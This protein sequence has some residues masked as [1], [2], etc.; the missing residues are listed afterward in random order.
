MRAHIKIVLCW[1]LVVVSAGS[2]A[3]TI[4]G[5]VT[6]SLGKPLSLV[7]VTLKG[8][9][10]V[11]I[12]FTS[13]KPTGVYTLEIPDDAPK[14][15]LTLEVSC[16]GFKKES[17][18]VNDPAA[19]INFK[20]SATSKKLNEVTIKNSRP[21]IRTAGDTTSYKVSDFSTPQD[22]V[23]GDVIKKLPGITVA[24]DGKISYNG[25]GVSTVYM[26]GDNLLD[27]KYNVATNSI[28]NK[29]VDQVQ[30]LENNQP[31]K[32]LQGKVVS[33]DVALNLTFKPD[34]KVKIVGQ[35]MLGGGLPGRY[36]EDLNAMAFKDRYKAINN[37]KG[38]NTGVDLANDVISH[39][40]G[41]YLG[42]LDNDKPTTVLSLGTAGDP[43]LPRSR[44]LFNQSGMINLNNLVN[45]TKE[46]QVKANMY[47][48]HDTQTQNYSKYSKLTLNGS[49]IVYTEQQ[50]NRRQPDILHGQFTLN[51]NKAKYYLNNT[52]LVDYNHNTNYSD[53][54]TNGVYAGQTFKD[55]AFDLSNEFRLINTTKG[56][57]IYEL[58]SYI[59][60]IGEPE[61][62]AITPGINQAD[63][64]GGNPYAQLVQGINIPTWFTN[65][66]VS[67]KIP[68]DAVTQS[69]K[70]GASL[71]SQ[72]VQSDL[73]VVQ[74]NGAINRISNDFNSLNWT[75]SKLYGEAAFD[76]PGKVLKLNITL[77]FVLQQI[78][79]K[80][81]NF[82]LDQ[83]LTRFYLNP[84][85]NGS[86]QVSVENK[87]SFGYGYTNR[88]G[89]IQ[90]VYR[91][92]VL[93]NYRSLYANSA[94]L[95]ESQT[96][97]VS[98][99]FNYRKA[100]T[101]FFFGINAAYI[102]TAANNISSSVVT[103]TQTSR[104]VV[105]L[106]NTFNV[107]QLGAS[108]SKYLFDIRSTVS[109]GIS[110]QSVNSNQLLNATL[111][112]FNTIAT[113][114][115]AGIDTK[116]SSKI[117]FSYKAYYTETTS[118]SSAISTTTSIQQL[119][120]TGS[121]NYAPVTDLNF[122]LS[123]DNYYTH[124]APGTDLKYTFAD[125]A[126]KYKFNKIK[127]DVELSAVNLFDTKT[128]SA[129]YLSANNFT[130]NTYTIPGRYILMKLFFNI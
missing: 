126:I 28:P 88:I 82:A 35:E 30:V 113:T 41:D 110:W 1:L 50:Q 3:Q 106:A 128:Y 39:N 59:D 37:V 5:T 96:Q 44:Y 21:H 32:A 8:S 121:I 46:I 116:V 73:N 77:P 24:D 67:Y 112:P 68:M 6:D 54:Y 75:K 119:Q 7:N 18:A 27:D 115:N 92:Y 109:A 100:I 78:D 36:E 10:N 48:L 87:L 79:Y 102:H 55:N 14:N 2:F 104:V 71:Q 61:N 34:A 74:N 43:D 122:R 40:L 83:S 9:G 114:Y 81:S 105:P 117:N 45:L 72:Q 101:L 111:Y 42:R 129:L 23:I 64:N 47:Y 63:Y 22:R 58:Y 89:S 108:T 17:K 56:N 95:T 66:Y 97:N 80:D 91:G 69:Y 93:K 52:L 53:L 90:D 29:S 130:S 57:K 65:N 62:R 25:K 99:G 12:A 51:V 26:G 125:F 31:I 84:K 124:Q 19:P 13:T 16:V 123:G 85:L 20:L 38:N 98:I 94:D 86:Y 120:Q 60:R 4:K 76:F 70:L 33:D 118:K 49:D 127:T 11:I 103:A 107:Y 15:G